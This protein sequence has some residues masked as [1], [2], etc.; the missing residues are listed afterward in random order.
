MDKYEQPPPLFTKLEQ[1]YALL[2]FDNPENSPFGY[3]MGLS[4]RT[5]LAYEVSTAVLSSL[6][7]SPISKL[8]HLLRMMV[9]LWIPKTFI[10]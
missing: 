2:A 9:W 3:L 6:E 10:L 4:Q 7:R 1:T 5:M 8:E